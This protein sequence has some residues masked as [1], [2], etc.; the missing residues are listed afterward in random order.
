MKQVRIVI[1]LIAAFCGLVACATKIEIEDV[2]I[3]LPAGWHIERDGASIVE[4]SPN[5]DMTQLP[6]LSI[7]I[8]RRSRSYQPTECHTEKIRETFFF[9]NKL[10][11]PTFRAK[12]RADGFTEYAGIA[13]FDDKGDSTHAAMRVL[14]SQQGIAYLGIFYEKNEEAMLQLLEKVTKSVRWN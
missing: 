10:K 13:V 9:P 11:K 3:D 4:A 8:Y 5:R 14:C 7:Q 2:S 12:L 6:N 1:L